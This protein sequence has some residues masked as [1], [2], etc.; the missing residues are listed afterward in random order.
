[1]FM[2]IKHLPSVVF[3]LFTILQSA[4]YGVSDQ[5]KVGQNPD[6]P[7]WKTNTTKRSIQLKDL[8]T[9]D[10]PVAKDGIPAIDQPRFI[11]V[12]EARNWLSDKEPVIA[13][14]VK[15]VNRAY[16][17][18]ILVWHE[19]INERI[20]GVPVIITY[21]SIC[22]SAIVFDRRLGRRIL[23]FGISGFVHGSNM[24]L[25]D[26]ETE[27]WWQ[28]FTGEAIVG[29][30]TGRKLSPLPAQIISFAQFAA[31]YPNAEVLSKETG[32]HR[33]YGRNP[34]FR[35][36]N[37]EGGPSHFRGKPD[38]R[39]RPME[40]VIG[41]EIAELAKAYPYAISGTRRVLYD[42]IGSQ[43]I[44][45]FHAE[46]ALS[47]LDATEMKKSKEAGSTGVF[48]PVVNGQR[49]NFR[50]ENG[51]FVDAETGS[52]WNILGMAI[53]G[54]HKGK[55]LKRIPHGDYFAFAWLAFKPKTMIFTE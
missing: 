6:Y 22:N 40:K 33:D 44:V 36:D 55:V 4:G 30:L 29:D 24:V 10:V 28:Q 49:L 43:Q 17:L 8:V 26:R 47:A 31:A 34:H 11:S 54:S 9:P 39:L 52:R 15:G 7:D 35:Y 14:Q 37:I 12:K 38:R 48:D 51:Q 53:S 45:I 50:Y 18:Q 21:C 1:M 20:A 19:V 13:L 41:I 32:H 23:T 27:S 2:R 16:P 42:Q 46:G 25:Y 5:R 3:I